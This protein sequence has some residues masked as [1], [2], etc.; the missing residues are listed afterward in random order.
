MVS[1]DPS[2]SDQPVADEAA[3]RHL[4]LLVALVLPNTSLLIGGIVQAGSLLLAPL[5]VWALCVVEV[6]LLALIFVDVL[7]YRRARAKPAK[8]G[9]LPNHSL[10]LTGQP[11]RG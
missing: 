5:W 11:R 4:D 3:L 6:L 7:G 2:S 8:K 1:C 9:A 10:Q